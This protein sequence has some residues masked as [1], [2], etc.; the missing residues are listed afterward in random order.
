MR[1]GN[2]APHIAPKKKKSRSGVY[3]FAR[4]RDG[5]AGDLATG[6][7]ASRFQDVSGPEACVRKG[8]ARRE[9]RMLYEGTTDL[10]YG[11]L[12]LCASLR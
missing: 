9:L 4:L 7:G 6:T 1:L 11:V 5:S 2:P 12:A 3:D 10:F 8:V